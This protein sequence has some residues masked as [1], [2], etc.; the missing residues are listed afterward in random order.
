[1]LFFQ[2]RKGAMKLTGGR[3]G[4]PT[5]EDDVSSC[6]FPFCV[7]TPDITNEAK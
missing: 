4:L 3:A 1:M 5:A 7:F 6:K 2:S